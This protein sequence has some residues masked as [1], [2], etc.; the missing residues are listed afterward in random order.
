M[1]NIT[2]TMISLDQKVLIKARLEVS[3]TT[4][5]VVDTVV[6]DRSSSNDPL[7]QLDW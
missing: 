3:V 4:L 6:L 5:M 2:T 7:F 1:D